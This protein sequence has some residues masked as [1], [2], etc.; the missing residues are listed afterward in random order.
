MFM[1][2][3]SGVG[4]GLDCTIVVGSGC[5]GTLSVTVMVV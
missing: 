1:Y 4:G 2:S 3:G 5:G